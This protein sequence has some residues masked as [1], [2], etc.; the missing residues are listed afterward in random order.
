MKDGDMTE[1]EKRL[2]ERCRH[3][4]LLEGQR[5]ELHGRL[6]AIRDELPMARARVVSA[7]RAVEIE[8]GDTPSTPETLEG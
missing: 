7:A 1:S 4:A 8:G 6:R 5:A 3:L 2:I